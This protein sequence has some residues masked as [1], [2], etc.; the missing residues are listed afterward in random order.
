MEYLEC[1]AN[2]GI[3]VAYLHLFPAAPIDGFVEWISAVDLSDL[4]QKKLRM[5]RFAMLVQAFVE[6]VGDRMAEQTDDGDRDSDFHPAC[7]GVYWHALGD[8]QISLHNGNIEL[9]LPP[10]RRAKKMGPSSGET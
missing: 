10:T 6:V 7:V 2:Y 9:D 1:P 8:L 3:A 4:E 5:E